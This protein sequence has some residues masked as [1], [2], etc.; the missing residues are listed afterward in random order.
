[1]AKG[2]DLFIGIDANAI[3][4]RAFHA[5]PASL[6]TSDGVQVNAVYGFTVMLLQVLKQFDP[7]Y[8]VCAFDTSKPTF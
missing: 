8:V 4:H 3:I 5:Y 1:M 7:K 2:K 6:T